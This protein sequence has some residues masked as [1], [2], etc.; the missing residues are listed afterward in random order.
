MGELY[1]D[2]GLHRGSVPLIP[3]L[4]KSQLYML[5]MQTLINTRYLLR[6][7]HSEHV[8]YS[9]FAAEG[10][11]VVPQFAEPTDT[12][13]SPFLPNYRLYFSF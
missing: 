10:H 1:A 5:N 13:I 3:V 7:I 12:F 11:D 8:V 9:C 4:F 2:F 6:L